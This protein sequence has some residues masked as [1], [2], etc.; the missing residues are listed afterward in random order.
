MIGKRWSLWCLAAALLLSLCGCTAGTEQ[1]RPQ[2][3]IGCDDYEPYNYADEDGEPAGMDVE[4][5]REACRRMGYEPVFRR[6]DWNERDAL[7]ESGEIDCLWSCFSMSGQE[8]A[9]A[10]VGLYMTSR[11]IVAVLEDSP[12]RT[13]GDLEGKSVGVRVGSKAEDIFLK[14]TEENIPLVGSV[15]S[16]NTVDELATALRNDYVDAIAGYAAAAREMLQND[17]IAFRF[18]DENLSEATLGVAFAK[19]SDPALWDK[20][21]AA[22]GEM[23]DDGTTREILAGY[24]VDTDKALGGLGD[25]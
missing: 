23:L 18:L 14:H 9:Y 11:Q 6:I 10:W 21:A 19:D 5:A 15:F 20:L 3:V 4:L 25:E 24:G 16:L 1:A 8:D 2:L 22:L 12:I 13:F 17:G 7:L